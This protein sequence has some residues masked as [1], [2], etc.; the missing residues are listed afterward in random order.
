M[1]VA[2]F[3]GTSIAKKSEILTIIDIVKKNLKKQPILVVSAISGVTEKLLSLPDAKKKDKKEI[4]SS[5]RQ[6][7]VKLINDLSLDE[8]SVKYLDKELA[9]LSE[10]ISGKKLS[11]SEMDRLVSYGEIISS[12]IIAN[13][14]VKNGIKSVQ[15]IATKLIVTDDNFQNAEF[16]SK[17][18]Q[19][20]T[21][22]ILYPL[23]KDG[24]V[25]V[26]T[27][28][29][30][31]NKK[32]Q[33]TT[34][35]RGGSDY[36]A[37]IIGFSLGVEEIQIWTDVDGIFTSDPRVVKS[38]RPLNI[39]SFREASELA[40]FGAKVLHPRTIKPAIKAGIPVRVL[41]TFNP[42]YAGSLIKKE[43][44]NVGFVKAISF[45]RNI[46][47]V[48]IYS[49]EMLLQK[50]FLVRVFQI[51]A[52]NKISIDLVS[53]SEVSVSVTLDNKEGLDKSIKTLSKFS[54]ITRSD[55]L[56][57]VSLIGEGITSAAHTIRRIFDILEREKILVRMISLGATDINISIVIESDKIE[58][59]VRVLHNR[60]LLRNGTI[61][62]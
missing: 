35:G 9:K 32:N 5:V 61:S 59:A 2:K 49:T 25:P 38:A 36:S 42:T 13:V 28:F 15:V 43:N 52:E 11:P 40:T 30:G 27:G 1:F 16:L 56:G 8:S 53:V 48:N 6:M 45:K 37:S 14:L 57:I 21:K 3:G 60:L 12:F 58:K 7:H 22:K 50:G 39:I 23:I 33:I 51:F 19:R 62:I 55:N 24:I 46:A 18:T 29:I 26:V 17:E 20:K 44:I 54:N 31:A 4:I 34:L 41:N 10:L 47:L